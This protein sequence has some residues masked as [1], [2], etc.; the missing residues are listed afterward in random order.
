MSRDPLP[1]DAH[2]PAIVEAVRQRPA[3]VLVADPGAGKSTRV[4]PALLPL[5]E[6]SIL[7]LQPR[8]IAARSLAARLAAELGERLG[9]GVGYAVRHERVG[10]PRTRLWVITEGLLTR[11]LLED[12]LLAGVGCVILDEFHERSLHSDL[13]VAWCGRV[14]RGLRPELR[15]VVM[16]ATLDP[17]PLAAYLEDCAVISVSAPR[18]PVQIVEGPA[19]DL[20][21]LPERVR[22]AV[23]REAARPEAGDLLVFLPGA[24][25]IAACA[26]ALA[27]RDDLAVL[28]LHGGLPPE[29]QEAALAPA[30]RRKVVL[31]TNVAETSLTI[32]GIR[33]VIDSGLQ[34]VN[35]FDPARGID[36]LSLEPCS[37]AAAAQ[38]AGRA[39]RSAPGRCLRLWSPL[40]QARMPETLEPE[41]RRVDLA[42]LLLAIKRL[43]GAD[44][45][46]FP[47]FEAPEP[48]R[49]EAGERLLDLLGAC[50]G[51]HGP[52]TALG[53]RLCA[54]PAHPR[55]ARL[56]LAGADAGLPRL[57]A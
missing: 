17:A 15:L 33:T 22:S 2:L 16:S 4:P 7:L 8:R 27:D 29:D 51:R 46:R 26:A 3:T 24:G 21:S 25:E 50:S 42:P 23:L 49:L 10:G 14:L 30:A 32:P 43:H 40:V 47:W 56:L 37:R 48:E 31:A 39:G 1:I 12:P 41:V 18:F 34:R 20:R 57:A 54:V 5:V 55:V 9:E 53:E 35:R 38:R 6:G 19:G 52:L 45:R 28:P 11:R 13:A 36:D 44:A